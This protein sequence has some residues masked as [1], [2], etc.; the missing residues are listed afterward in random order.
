MSLIYTDYRQ[1]SGIDMSPLGQLQSSHLSQEQLKSYTQAMEKLVDVVQHLSLART[2]DEITAIVRLA[3]RDLTGADGATFVLRDGDQCYYADENAI[4][5]LWKGRRFPLNICISGHCIQTR[6]IIV[7]EDIYQDERIPIEAYRPTFVKSLVMVPI[8]QDAPIG[9]IGNY[10]ANFHQATPEEIKLLQALA[11]TTS[12]AIEKII[13]YQELE[14][15]VQ[16]RTAE[17]RMVNEELEAF[18]YSISHDLRSPLSLINNYGWILKNK[19]EHQLEPKAVEFLHKMCAGAERMNLQIDQ[20]LGLYRLNQKEMKIEPLNLTQ[21]AWDILENLQ[22]FT[23]ERQV[24]I[25]MADNCQAQ[26]DAT[27]LQVVLENLLENAWKYTAKVEKAVIELGKIIQE[28]DTPC[29]FVRDNGAGFNMKYATRLFSPFQRMHTEQEFPGTGI[30]LASVRR[31]IQRHGG[32]IW[33]EA[34]VNQGATFY[35]TLSLG[36]S[37]SIN[38]ANLI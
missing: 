8:R 27:L 11:D 33:A 22:K 13:L 15:R 35:F 3:A 28:D 17:L 29:F 14:Q 20:V 30:G 38:L 10:W 2:L 1:E 37:E 18:S 21:M 36:L 24:E 26:G 23:P 5:P 34:G 19:Y 31:I 4:S 25:K 16:Q 12:V 32:Q 9:A 7:I 6:Q